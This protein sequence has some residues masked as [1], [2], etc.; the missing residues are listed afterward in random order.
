MRFLMWNRNTFPSIL[1][2]REILA[3]GGLGDPLAMHVDF[4]FAKDA[5][6]LLGS[7]EPE[8]IPLGHEVLGELTVE[9]IYPLAYFHALLGVPVRRVFA[10]TTAHFFQRHADR[11]VEDLASVT[12]EMEDGTPGSLC[13]GRIGGTLPPQH[14]RA[15]AAHR[16]D[17]GRL[18]RPPSRGPRSRSMPGP[19][20][21]RT[22]ASAAWAST[23]S[24]VC[25]TTS[26]GPSTRGRTP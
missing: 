18:R 19:S 26:A 15:A 13:I 10:R 25:W 22:T 21:P 14:R 20:S 23:T 5:G 2:A 16:G 3:G 17:Q 4:F 7:G 24:A 6:V 1:Q 8:E 11:G 9:G 12:L